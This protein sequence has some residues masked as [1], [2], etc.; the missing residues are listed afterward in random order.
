MCPVS[1][2][3]PRLGQL[4]TG[5]AN[6]PAPAPCDRG[7]PDLCDLIAL[8]GGRPN[9]R[10]DVD[11]PVALRTVKEGAALLVEGAD[12]TT[13][14]IVRSGSL[15]SSRTLE[16]GYEQVL[17]LALVG[18]L[19]G[20]EAL[21]AGRQP[22]SVVAL[23]DST[24]YVLPVRDLPALRRQ[25]PQLDLV[26]QVALSRQLVR[27]AEITAMAAA[28]AS[29]VKLARFLLWLS[30]RMQEI[31]QSPSRL[32]LRLCRREIASLICVAHETVSRSFTL[33]AELGCV[34]VDRRE[35]QIVDPARLRELARCTRGTPQDL[36][37]A[38][39]PVA[40]IRRTAWFPAP[41][42]LAPAAA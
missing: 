25:D 39:P 26:L 29:E 28:V 9:D 19:M 13:L 42:P 37:A 12:S 40:P 3:P 38:K 14:Y 41:R 27:A 8:L 24:V 20:A 18:E 2:S 11:V 31:G 36:L 17:A 16:D 21:H 30:D 15:K 32:L 5:P 1:A 23:E 35:V 33:L 34:H 22:A 10:R 7:R 6:R 4:P